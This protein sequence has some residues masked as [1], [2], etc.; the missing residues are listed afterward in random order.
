VFGATVVAVNVVVLADRLVVVL[1]A[2][3]GVAAR[4]A[5]APVVAAGGG[6]EHAAKQP[7]IRHAARRDSRCLTPG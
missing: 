5:G 4:V 7:V 1:G 6:D 2:L 3:L